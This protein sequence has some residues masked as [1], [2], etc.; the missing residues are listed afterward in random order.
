MVEFPI[1][2]PMLEFSMP[3]YYRGDIYQYVNIPSIG[4]FKFSILFAQHPVSLAWRSSLGTMVHSKAA[5]VNRE[6]GGSY[7]KDYKRFVES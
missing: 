6:S 4:Y 3:S 2:S 5:V 7:A 1:L